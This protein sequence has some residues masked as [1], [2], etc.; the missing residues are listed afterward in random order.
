[1][2]NSWEPELLA[3]RVYGHQDLARALGLDRAED[4][5]NA[6]WGAG[7]NEIMG[8]MARAVAERQAQDEMQARMIQQMLQNQ[9]GMDI[10]NTQAATQRYGA[11]QQLKGHQLQY[12]T[13]AQTEA[14]KN[15]TSM[16]V[17][18]TT[19]G[20]SMQNAQAR[21]ASDLQGR[22]MQYRGQVDAAKIKAQ[23]AT[24][25]QAAKLIPEANRLQ[26]FQQILERTGGDVNAATQAW[27][28]I[29]SSMGF[30]GTPLPASVAGKAK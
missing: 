10:A 13:Q 16:D 12:E 14:A 8:A 7:D 15:K 25:G 6:A 3:N 20:A 30:P 9:G 22:Q 26:M 28:Q 1:M 17:A 11:D 2:A 24:A 5:G 21:A 29:V 4:Y 19:A 27:A 23:G 18:K